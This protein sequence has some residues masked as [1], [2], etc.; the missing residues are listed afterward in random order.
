MTRGTGVHSFA[1]SRAGDIAGTHA[2]IA[3]DIAGTPARSR[4]SVRRLATVARVESL[5]RYRV[6]LTLDTGRTLTFDAGR[7]VLCE[8]SD[9][10]AIAG[11]PNA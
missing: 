11:G 1:E 8:Y 6:R 7:W 2:R 4:A 3:L 9:Y 10:S 5:P